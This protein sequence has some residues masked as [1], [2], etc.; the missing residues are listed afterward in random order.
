M[1]FFKTFILLLCTTALFSSS[2]YSTAIKEKKIYPMGKKVYEKKCQVIDPSHYDSYEQL[3]QNIKTKNLCKE[4][5]QKHFEAM[6]LYLWEVKREDLK[7]KHFEKFHPSKEDK[8]PVCG[9]FVYKYPTWIAKI[10]YKSN[11]YYFDGV[12]DMLKY[13]FQHQQDI[14]AILV[15]DYYTYKILDAKKAFFVIGS[16]VYGPMGNELIAFET[17]NS[18]QR[19]FVD[20]KGVQILKFYEINEDKVYSLDD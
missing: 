7:E 10:E 2:N 13:Y 18:A 4:L 8:C 3:Q 11:V 20:H 6:T 19:F 9:M 15:Q 5:N 14:K 17:L 1:P 12:K 16:D